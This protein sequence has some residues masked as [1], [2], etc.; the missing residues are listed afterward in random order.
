ML[1]DR[2]GEMVRN[3]GS[4]FECV[5]VS[6]CVCLCVSVCVCVCVCVS[7][8]VSLC[9]CVCVRVCLCLCVCGEGLTEHSSSEVWTQP[10]RSLRTQHAELRSMALFSLIK[11]CTCWSWRMQGENLAPRWMR[12]S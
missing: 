12:D 7:A 10:E 5:C 4:E 2:G 8:C 1:V 6:V 11:L 3:E 9:V